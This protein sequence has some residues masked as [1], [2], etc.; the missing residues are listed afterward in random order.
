MEQSLKE[1]LIKF[2]SKGS[3]S[4][5]WI[6]QLTEANCSQVYKLAITHKSKSNDNYEEFEMFGDSTLNHAILFWIRSRYP[7]IKNVNWLTKIKH[8]LV[9]T[10]IIGSLGKNLGIQDLVIYDSD[11]ISRDS[12]DF[13]KIVEDVMESM[14]GATMICITEKFK[15]DYGVGYQICHNIVSTLLDELNPALE[16]E[17]IWDPVTI[18][19]EMYDV[20]RWPFFI[21]IKDIDKNKAV[22]SINH[23]TNI[24]AYQTNLI[25]VNRDIYI[26]IFNDHF[27]PTNEKQTFTLTKDFIIKIENLDFGNVGNATIAAPRF[28]YNKFVQYFGNGEQLVVETGFKTQESKIKATLAENGYKLLK[29]Y[30]HSF[31]QPPSKYVNKNF[32]DYAKT[33]AK[34]TQYKKQDQTD[35]Q[36]HSSYIPPQQQR[37]HSYT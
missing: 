9:S 33:R 11:S 16:Y 34:Y 35:Q 20:N 2:L 23:W 7:E 28:N 31:K 12:E 10:K 15:L 36:R 22:Y 13:E 21:I 32:E 1:F 25:G 19:K 3:V 8:Y 37:Y 30:G 18:L 27:K 14:L 5:S 17:N 6:Q 29:S 26:Q 24:N 4:D